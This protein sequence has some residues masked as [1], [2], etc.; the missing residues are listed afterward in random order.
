MS[1]TVTVRI[2]GKQG[3]ETDAPSVGDLLDQIR[4]YF[5]LL[6]VVEAALAEDGESA[7]VWRVVDAVRV[8]PFTFTIQAFARQYAVNVDSRANKVVDL[9]ISGLRLLEMRAERPAYFTEQ[10]LAKAERIFERVTNGLD[11]T[12]ILTENEPPVVLTP[13]VARVAVRN[14]RSVRTPAG[15]PYK[16]FGSIEGYFQTVG[17]D[18]RGGGKPVLYIKSRTTGDEIKCFVSGEAEAEVSHAE[19][20]DVWRGRRMSVSGTIHY[21]CPGRISHVDAVRIRFLRN[22]RDLP[23]IDDIIDQD[24]TGGLRSEE[25]LERLRDG[26][27]S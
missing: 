2:S 15:R 23:D 17:S 20:G 25:Y 19:V 27:L 4:D 12:E 6:G 8:N 16:E 5:D 9:A 24:F 26:E 10:A 1:R 11:Q 14:A 7:I 18:G 3:P 21:R 22:R 13:D